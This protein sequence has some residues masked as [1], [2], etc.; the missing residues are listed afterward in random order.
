MSTFSTPEIDFFYVLAGSSTT[1]LQPEVKDFNI[2]FSAKR[3][4]FK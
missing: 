3:V 2:I 1:E 4:T